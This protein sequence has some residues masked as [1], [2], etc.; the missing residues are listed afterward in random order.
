M[1]FLGKVLRHLVYSVDQHETSVE[2]ERK[3]QVKSSGEKSECIDEHNQCQSE[4]CNI[5]TSSKRNAEVDVTGN[6]HNHSGEE[7]LTTSEV[8]DAIQSSDLQAEY[9]RQ[10]ARPKVSSSK[11]NDTKEPNYIKNPTVEFYDCSSKSYK[12]KKSLLV[13]VNKRSEVGNIQSMTSV[14]QSQSTKEVLLESNNVKIEQVSGKELTFS[15]VLLEADESNEQLVKVSKVEYLGSIVPENKT[16]KSTRYTQCDLEDEFLYDM[17]D[18]EQ[19]QEIVKMFQ[20]VELEDV[21]QSLIEVDS[22]DVGVSES[23]VERSRS[24]I[25]QNLNMCIE[26]VKISRITVSHTASY[27]RST[28]KHSHK[29]DV[30]GSDDKYRRSMQKQYQSRLYNFMG[31]HFNYNCNIIREIFYVHNNRVFLHNNI[32]NF[33]VHEVSNYK[34]C[35]FVLQLYSVLHC[36]LLLNRYKFCENLI[37]NRYITTSVLDMCIVDLLTNIQS[38]NMSFCRLKEIMSYHHIKKFPTVMGCYSSNFFLIY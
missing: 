21:D 7:Y 16:L 11:T 27:S 12:E 5:E 31:M 24:D 14:T 23:S 33:L 6:L 18:Y 37:Y 30:I 13:Q 4:M 1:K 26:S 19:E 2:Y 20:Q 35:S 10:G 25:S 8:S 22:Y 36:T 32:V 3:E 29:G 9:L 38:T 17:V 15:P 34:L 28:K